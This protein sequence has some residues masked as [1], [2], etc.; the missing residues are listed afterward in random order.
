MI[1]VS[2]LLA[3]LF[4][5]FI[6][7]I[8]IFLLTLKLIEITPNERPIINKTNKIKSNVSIYYNTIGVPQIEASNLNDLYFAI[9]YAQAESR[10]WQM[11]LLR[12]MAN[13]R[14]SEILGVDYIT[15]DKFIRFF[16]LKNT[17]QE[18]FKSLPNDLKSLLVSY[19]DGVNYFIMENSENLAIEFS[20][21]DYTPNF[22]KPEDCIL[23]FN[24]LEFYL[25]SSFKDNLFDLV[26]K[27]KLSNLEYLNLKGKALNFNQSDTTIFNKTSVPE[28]KK[29]R[30]NSL[31]ALFDSISKYNFLFNNIN[32]N[33][34]AIRS[35]SNSFYK[36]AI[37][38]DF[39]TEL[40]IPSLGMMILANSP[41]VSLNG[42][43]IPGIPLCISGKN[44]F[45]AWATNF[46]YSSQWYFEEI[47]LDANQSH[48]VDSI[49]M[50]KPIQF[51]IDTIYV[52]N[53]YPRLF[54]LKFAKGKG[55]FTEAFEGI[56][57]NL[58]ANQPMDLNKNKAFEQLY[59]LNF[60]RQVNDVKHI[61]NDW[62]SPRVNILFG[63][64]FGN[65]GITSLGISFKDNNSNELLQNN[66]NFVLNPPNNY[67][68]STNLPI[69]TATYK[70]FD[71]NFRS[72]RIASFLSN[73]PDFEIRDIKNIQLD[74]K[75]E[76]AKEL[77]SIIIPII[78]DK[79]YLLN[80]EEKKIF[81]S[82]LKWDCSYSRNQQQPVV[83]EEFIKNLI[84]T[85]LSDNLEKSLI[86]HFYNSF[87]FYEQLIDILNNKYSVLFDDIRTNEIENRDYIVFV[88]AKQTFQ[89]LSKFLGKSKNSKFYNW[90]NYNKG[91]FAHFYYNN[92]IINSTFSI[93]SIEM[94]GHP[95]CINI[96]KNIFSSN[97]SFGI[98]NRTIFDSQY[99]GL[100]CINSLGNSGD[101]TNDHFLDQFQVWK[102]GGYLKISFEPKT[103]FSSNRRLFLPKNK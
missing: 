77:L 72:K 31:Y 39:A 26:L 98:I 24:F 48:F 46:V 78:K 3:I 14:L 6:I 41:E 66:S 99:L 52:K 76:F 44:N 4:S 29:R 51:K 100:Y 64:K 71:F 17:A 84:F 62:Y 40:S 54:Y 25:N 18:T 94:N 21:L 91:G 83:I 38:N 20:I 65:I 8:A 12:R 28:S 87:Y 88:C 93:D 47:K 80:E 37:A 70:Q 82:L 89:K 42:I 95:T 7:F 63:D 60:Y 90:G 55:L 74:T 9:G 22:W 69:D 27:E 10:M 53:S 96:S 97:F 19:S 32:G 45:L 67:I 16:N 79:I 59:Y 81:E 92:R 61:K 43:F 102:N 103:R 73:L 101:P 33:T 5:L 30:Y 2:N 35:L 15:Y 49:S 11:D 86:N 58:I 50:P 85:I 34:F 13:G 23:I 57:L 75:S 56:D 36:S 68:I 1:K